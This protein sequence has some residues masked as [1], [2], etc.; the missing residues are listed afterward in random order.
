MLE[1]LK[2]SVILCHLER[3]VYIPVSAEAEFDLLIA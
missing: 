2:L 3:S 1:L